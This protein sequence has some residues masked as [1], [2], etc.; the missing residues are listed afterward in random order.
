MTIYLSFHILPLHF[1]V[2]F[3]VFG[4]FFLLMKTIENISLKYL[5]RIFATG[6]KNTSVTVG[7]LFLSGKLLAEK[8]S[9][10][11]ICAQNLKCNFQIS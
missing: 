11:K 2:S 3:A 6:K 8:K 9:D 7:A 10:K 4:S 5:K 1:P